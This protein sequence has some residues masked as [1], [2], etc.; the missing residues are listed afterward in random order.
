MDTVRI[1]HQQKGILGLPDGDF[2]LT[3]FIKVGNGREDPS[4]YGFGS[5]VGLTTEIKLR[6]LELV[7]QACD[8]CNF[9]RS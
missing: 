7:C 3:G 9:M 2:R 1:F 8:S 6:N 4:P 5:L